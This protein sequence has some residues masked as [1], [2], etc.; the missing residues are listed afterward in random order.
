MSRPFRFGVAAVETRSGQG[1]LQFA[2]RVEAL[3]YATL[4]APDHFGDHLAPIAALA[5]AAAATSTLRI[6]SYVFDNDFRHPVVLAK[7][8]ATLDLLSNGRLE[9]GLGA[10]WLKTEYDQAGLTFDPGAVRL[11][12]LAEAIQIVKGLFA[13]QPLTFEG[14]HYRVT[15][16]LGRPRP[17]QR[18]G[19]PLFVGGGRRR[20]LSLAAREADIVNIAPGARLDGSGL[21]LDDI[22]PEALDR[23]IGWLRQ[24]A[25]D[26]FDRLELSIF[27]PL[28][29]V[30]DRRQ[31]AAERL[32]QAYQLP[33]ERLLAS[34]HTLIGSLGEIQEQLLER[35]ERYGASYTVVF[36]QSAEAFAPIVASLAGR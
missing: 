26:R 36:E 17:V 33:A 1:W 9:L 21:D 27:L 23:K 5:A 31:A 11:A 19:P 2:R 16:L 32:E 14:A 30:T 13:E 18:P 4:L 15:N 22:T 28:V 10:G 29:E 25:G 35:R 24:A 34:P 3:G 20:L 8:A 6:G 12:R 7:E